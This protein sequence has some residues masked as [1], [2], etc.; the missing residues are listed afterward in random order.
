VVLGVCC[1]KHV[2]YHVLE[3]GLAVARI[4]RDVGSIAQTVLQI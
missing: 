1:F 4:A 2:A 3:E